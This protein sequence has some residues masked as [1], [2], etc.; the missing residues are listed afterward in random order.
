[1]NHIQPSI[2]RLGNHPIAEREGYRISAGS[3]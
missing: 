1:V 2:S 3:R